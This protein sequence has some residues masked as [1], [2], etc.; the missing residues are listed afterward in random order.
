[1][2]QNDAPPDA[3]APEVVEVES[4]VVS[5]DGGGVLGHPKVWLN[6]HGRGWVECGYCDRR[7][8]LKTSG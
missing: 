6:M 7:F 3:Q 2:A 5:C 8:V 4:E 1:M